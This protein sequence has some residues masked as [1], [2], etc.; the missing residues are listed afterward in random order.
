MEISDQQEWVSAREAISLLA[1]EYKASSS[2][3]VCERAHAG[4]I[5]AKAELF[6]FDQKERT[7]FEIPKDF[8]WAKGHEALKQNWGSGDF[9]TWIDNTYHLQA[10]GVSFAREDIQKLLPKIS[11]ARNGGEKLKENSQQLEYDY[12]ASE[13]IEELVRLNSKEWD[14]RKLVRLCQEL[15]AAYA[16]KNY[17]SVALLARAVIDHVP[18]IFGQKNFE[19]VVAQHGTKSF[20]EAMSHLHMS[21]RKIAD[22]YLHGQIRSRE[23]LPNANTVD[24]RRDLDVLLGEVIRII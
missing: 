21:M 12:V 14:T 3:V 11:S 4:L 19:N 2:F 22:S 8:W 15:N 20:K 24:V 6:K 23:T 13:R 5:R 1:N 9:S 18:P 7:D 17:I 10:F 16:A